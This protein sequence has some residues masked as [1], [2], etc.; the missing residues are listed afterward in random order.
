MVSFF[1][2]EVSDTFALNDT[3]KARLT[4][5]SD[6]FAKY[7]D[8]DQDPNGDSSKF[9][10]CIR[11]HSKRELENLKRIGF[12]AVCRRAYPIVKAMVDKWLDDLD[13]P[14]ALPQTE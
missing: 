13:H 10:A 6:D 7:D 1:E 2:T 3:A 12:S 5:L 14:S 4:S 8:F 9:L 11:L